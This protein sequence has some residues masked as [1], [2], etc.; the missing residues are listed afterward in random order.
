MI[1]LQLFREVPC[2]G[3]NK[4]QVKRCFR[5][6]S[7]ASCLHLNTRHHHHFFHRTQTVATWSFNACSF[8]FYFDSVLF[9]VIF[10]SLFGSGAEKSI[11]F[12]SPSQYQFFVRVL[13]HDANVIVSTTRITLKIKLTARCAHMGALKIFGRSLSLTTPTATF[14]DIL[15]GLLFRLSLLCA[16]KIGSK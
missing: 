12:T 11:L 4:T 5:C 13:V 1:F 14:A 16:Y 7:W 6:V 15:N 8:G 10:R 2:R 3:T 9:F